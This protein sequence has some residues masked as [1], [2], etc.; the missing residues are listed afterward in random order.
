MKGKM[1][2]AFKPSDIKHC[3][4]NEPRVHKV[5]I[6]CFSLL[7]GAIAGSYEWFFNSVVM[8]S[9]Q[10]QYLALAGEYS[11]G[12]FIRSDS[13]EMWAMRKQ[14][15]LLEAKNF[16]DLVKIQ[17][18]FHT[19]TYK[20]RGVG[21]LDANGNLVYPDV[22]YTVNPNGDPTNVGFYRQESVG[23]AEVIARAEYVADQYEDNRIAFD[24][25]RF[26][27]WKKMRDGTIYYDTG[28]CLNGPHIGDI[29]APS[30]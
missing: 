23:A 7:M 27:E 11:F 6:V 13:N 29:N 4:E 16:D 17:E 26:D 20:R 9:T 8:R 30:V 25:L 22:T 3:V 14:L 19:T 5:R 18:D 12:G 1:Q 2:M 10:M 21:Q 28:A 15:E 24:A